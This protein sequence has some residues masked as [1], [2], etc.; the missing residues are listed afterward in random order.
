MKKDCIDYVLK[1]DPCQIFPSIPRAL[2]NEITLMTSPW[3][4]AVWR[5]DLIGSLPMGKF[6]VKYAI[7]VVDYYT[8]WTEV[9]PIKIITAKKVLVF[10]IKNI[11]SRY[12]LPHKIVSD[13]GKQFDCDEFTDFC[14]KHKV[15]KSFSTVARPQ[16][17]GQAEAVNKIL[18][19]ILMEKL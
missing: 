8:K 4:F 3:P 1:C 12:G 11:V 13:N 19:V 16:T 6:G 9:E 18:K 15:I 7:V 17:N 2:P 5:I 10:V 14:N